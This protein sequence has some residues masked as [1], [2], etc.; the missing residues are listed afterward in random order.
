[1]ND[2]VILNARIESVTGRPVAI[3]KLNVTALIAIDADLSFQQ[4]FVVDFI[5]QSFALS[6]I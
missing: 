1:M 4:E 5:R 2:A 6:G 3:A